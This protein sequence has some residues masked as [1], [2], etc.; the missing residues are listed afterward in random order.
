MTVPKMDATIRNLDSLAGQGA[1]AEAVA[2]LAHPQPGDS[3][4]HYRIEQRCGEGGMG[5]VYRAWDCALERPAA[6]K[7][8][9]SAAGWSSNPAIRREAHA[10]S[11]L[12]HPNIATFFEV[13]EIH[14]QPYLALEFVDGMSLAERLRAGPLAPIELQRLGTGLLWALAHA[15]AAGVLHCDIK[16]ANIVLRPDGDAVLL[17]FGIAKLLQA[18][19]LPADAARTANGMVNGSPGYMAPEQLTGATL[20]ERSDLYAVALVLLEALTGE[21]GCS[22]RDARE[23]AEA[24]LRGEPR[25]RAAQLDSPL[26]TLLVRA[27]SNDPSQRPES[28][29][30]MQFELQQLWH[31]TDE[32]RGPQRMLAL[33]PDCADL[34]PGLR[35]IATAVIQTIRT[36][37]AGQSNLEL[38]S[39]P[40]I[41]SARMGSGAGDS[42]RLGQQLGCRWVLD[43]GIAGDAGALHIR[44]NLTDA[45]NGQS[46][47]RFE[48]VCALENIFALQGRLVEWLS[49]Q[50]L[51]ITTT[52]PRPAFDGSEAELCARAELAFRKGGKDGMTESEACYRAVLEHNPDSLPALSGLAGVL[53]LRY[54]FT[55]NPVLLVEAERLARAAIRL[56]S[57]AFEARTWLVYVLLRQGRHRAGIA[58]AAAAAKGNPDASMALYFGASCHAALSRWKPALALY[59]ASLRIDRGR[60]FSW[61]GAAWC[62]QR[63][64]RLEEALFCIRTA[65]RLET[66]DGPLRTAGCGA[67]LGEML[68]QRGELDLAWRETH[69]ALQ[70]VEHSDFFYRDSFRALALLTLGRIALDRADALAAQTAFNQACAALEARPSMLGGG[71]LM[72]Q[73]LAGSSLSAHEP[74]SLERARSLYQER[75]APW[76][77]EWTWGC[78]N[79]DT[80]LALE[81]GATH[82][83]ALANQRP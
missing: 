10:L 49:A 2:V 15:H 77:F 55:T 44:L 68:R 23:R 13:G 43:G 66:E 25:Q 46:V 63:I 62:H 48:T 30:A 4:G 32:E 3:L 29:A 52:A 67:F 18:D 27:L 82:Y 83:R 11:R 39:P 51:D 72:V 28:A 76:S 36:A 71:H 56:D 57:N 16:P 75:P 41:A 73:A 5:S 6:V 45:R 65:E 79:A 37:M 40:A 38:A 59:Q 1:E 61:I 70:R 20:S 80:E 22:G 64:G 33:E 19:A 69:T 35:W 50:L 17:D 34:D 7:L 21:P 24:T 8:L 14:G 81:L 54:I 9:H 60:C 42:L 26:R 58:Q 31:H 12:Q 78:S 74:A 53:P 47:S